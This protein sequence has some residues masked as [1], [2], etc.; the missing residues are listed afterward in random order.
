MYVVEIFKKDK[1]KPLLY[2]KM[3]KG[4]LRDPLLSLHNY[5][6]KPIKLFWYGIVYISYTSELIC[7]HIYIL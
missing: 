1:M 2:G 7:V 6:N 3:L 5:A 4:R